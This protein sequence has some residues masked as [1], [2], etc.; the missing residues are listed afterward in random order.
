MLD[1]LGE[2]RIDIK[3]GAERPWVLAVNQRSALALTLRGPSG[4]ALG[5]Q[6]REAKRGPEAIRPGFQQAFGLGQEAFLILAHRRDALA[7]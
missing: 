1:A 6:P 4:K 7:C 5:I 2:G 3:H